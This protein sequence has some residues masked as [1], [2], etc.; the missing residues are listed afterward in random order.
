MTHTYAILEVSEAAYDEIKA[1]LTDANCIHAFHGFHDD[2]IDMHGIA[3]KKSDEICSK[4]KQPFVHHAH[5]DRAAND[6]ICPLPEPACVG[7]DRRYG[8]IDIAGKPWHIDEDGNTRAPCLVR[9]QDS[10]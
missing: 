10:R 4:C 3:L 9:R 6:W 2:V 8:I 5:G 1:K 7:C